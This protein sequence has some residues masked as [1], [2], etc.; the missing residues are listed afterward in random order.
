MALQSSFY[1]V[2][3]ELTNFPQTKHIPNKDYVRVY[4]RSI[5]DGSWVQLDAS[6][7][8][9]INNSIVLVEVIDPDIYDMI[10]VRISD[11][12]D[13]LQDSIS[14]IAI[15]SS[16]ASDV[17]TVAGIKDEVLIVSSANGEITTVATDIVN[18]SSVAADIASVNNVSGNIGEVIIVATDISNV[19]TVAA[20]IT[21][22]IN[23]STNMDNVLIVATDIANVNTVA[24]NIANVNAVGADITNVNLVADKINDVNSYAR[25]YYGSLASDPTTRPDGSEMLSG[26]LYFNTTVKEMRVYDG[27]VWKTVAD[28]YT[29]TEADDRFVNVTGDTISGDLAFSSNAIGVELIDRTTG[30]TYRIFIDNGNFGIEEVV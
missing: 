13:E 23:V 25:T 28:T 14:D 5:V 12:I 3:G 6:N 8:D 4:L 2:D 21:N 26:D 9:V 22:V 18:V 20:D 1:A 16:I 17:T 11:L 15:V 19:N 30:T 10:E 29:R 7:Y 24:A 27:T